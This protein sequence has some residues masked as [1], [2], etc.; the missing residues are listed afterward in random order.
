M[1]Y[2]CDLF[3]RKLVNIIACIQ[4]DP[5]TGKHGPI[6]AK[7]MEHHSTDRLVLESSMKTMN[8]Q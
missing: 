8:N 6:A 4:S 1:M 5:E 3:P 2:L 7:N